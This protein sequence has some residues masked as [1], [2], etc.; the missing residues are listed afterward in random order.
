[1]SS[2]RNVFSKLAAAVALLAGGSAAAST[3]MH[4]GVRVARAHAR[5]VQ[6]RP[7]HWVGDQPAYIDEDGA[8]VVGRRWI[9]D[10][11]GE[12]IPDPRDVYTVLEDESYNVKTTA[13]IDFLF[14]QGY[15][16]TGLGTNGLN[17]IALSNDTL[18]ET[19]A[20]TTLSTEI[21][22]NGLTRAQGTYAHS[23]GTSTATIS[24]TFT[25]TGAQ[26]CQKAALFTA[27][28][29]GTMNHALSFAQRALQTGDTISI[30]FTVTIS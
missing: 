9:R 4:E 8:V 19:S 13:G 18:T 16:T 29:A 20:S 15:A 24:K 14:L 3:N 10:A 12:S 27:V 1:M 28:S 21:A 11:Q 23:G 17:F 26:S 30:S 5:I 7:L 22:A 2:L 6:Q 25:A